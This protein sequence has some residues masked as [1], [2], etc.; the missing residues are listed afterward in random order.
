MD[1]S[2]Y[3]Q[4]SN[5]QRRF[6]T[7]KNTFFALIICLFF[8]PLVIMAQGGDEPK[9][10]VEKVTEKM[11]E[12]DQPQSDSL[13]QKQDFAEIS[14]A[15]GKGTVPTVI[16]ALSLAAFIAGFAILYLPKKKKEVSNG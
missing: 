6:Y 7:L 3:K 12:K 9:E 15:V 11:L 2:N 13:R 1:K 5:L 14:K 4:C 10:K 8:S 16:K